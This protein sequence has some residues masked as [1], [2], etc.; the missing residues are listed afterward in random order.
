MKDWKERITI[1]PNVLVGKPILKGTRLAVEFIIDLLANGWSEQEIMRN[2]PGISYED[3][4]ACLSYASESLK[5]EKV[6]N[7]PIQR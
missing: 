7:L 6:Y 1:D 2:Y 3:I 4:R 5:G